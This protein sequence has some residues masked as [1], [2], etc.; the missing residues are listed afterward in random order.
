MNAFHKQIFDMLMESQYWPPEQMLAFQRDQLAQLLRHAKATVPFYKTRL[1]VVFRKNGDIDW[2]RWNEIP[3]VTRADVR[4]RGEDMMATKLPR[5]HGRVTRNFT[6]G[7][8]G[9]PISIYKNELFRSASRAAGKRFSSWAG[10]DH[11][12]A[13]ADFPPQLYA[14][15]NAHPHYKIESVDSAWLEEKPGLKM[16]ISR[17]LAEPTALELLREFN[18]RYVTSLPNFVEMLAHANL[19]FPQP[20]KL[21]MI[22]CYGMQALG[23]QIDL[24]QRS[25]GAETYNSYSSEEAARIAAQCN[26]QGPYHINAEQLLVEILNENGGACARGEAGSVVLTMFYSTAQPLIRYEI[27]DLAQFG[28]HCPCG[29]NLP[30]LSNILGR[31]YPIFIRPDGEKFWVQFEHEIIAKNLQCKSYQIAQTGALTFE[32][33]YVPHQLGQPRNLEIVK[34]TVRKN[35]FFDAEVPFRVMENI[36]LGKGGKPQVLVREYSV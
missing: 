27:G 13:R 15:D 30:T 25:F 29:R 22:L 6:S 26:L 3:I 9:I 8:T 12:K 18:V 19:D 21:E 33:R 1:D 4:D 11:A 34:N 23:T 20:I 14:P 35:L 7:S 2:N 28:E 36:P 10:I 32:V 31:L 5:G 17:A 16:L 24:F